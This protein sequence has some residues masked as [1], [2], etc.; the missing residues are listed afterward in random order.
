MYLERLVIDNIKRIRKE[1]GISQEKLAEDCN[2]S[3]SYIGLMEIYKNVPKLS[4]IE[5]IAEALKVDPLM[6]FRD[7]NKISSEKESEIQKKK[8]Q[9]L[10]T[11]EKE[12]DNI[13]HNQ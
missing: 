1:K 12:L 6:F 4:T 11:F 2:T 10:L 8:G 9:I 3:T 13:L 5:R 7:T